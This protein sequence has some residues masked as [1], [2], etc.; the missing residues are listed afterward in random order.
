ML[1]HLL[2]A[3]D[4]GDACRQAYPH[5]ELLARAF[6]SRVTVLHVDEHAEGFLPRVRGGSENAAEEREARLREVAAR[7]EAAGRHVECVV[8]PGTPSR[9][10]LAYA[11]HHAVALIIVAKQG[12]RT[13]H[14]LW[15]GSTSESVMHEAQV[16]AL[17]A[18][19]NQAAGPIDRY[20][21]L[22]LTTDYSEDS[23]LGL[24]RIVEITEPFDTRIE[25]IHAVPAPGLLGANPLA[26]ARTVESGALEQH[27]QQYEEELAAHLAGL[28]LPRVEGHVALGDTIADAIAEHAKAAGADLIA[29]PTHGKGALSRLLLGSTT[30]QVVRV[31]QCPVLVMPR[32]WLRAKGSVAG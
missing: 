14:P 28:G 1:D 31:S 26:V 29:M 10:I 20:R 3:T 32:V 19:G 27:R 5:A 4:L 30:R 6:K 22:L 25:V 11:K 15:V 23:D 18:C 8:E 24:R 12:R 2:V 13:L 17:I 9:A 7:F 16:P 21:R